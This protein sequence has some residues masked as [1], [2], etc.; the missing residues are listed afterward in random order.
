MLDMNP[1]AGD[2]SS[3]L[4]FLGNDGG[5]YL[6]PLNP[7]DIRTDATNDEDNLTVSDFD[8]HLLP[9][10]YHDDIIESFEVSAPE[11]SLPRRVA[12]DP[13]VGSQ[14]VE[15]QRQSFGENAHFCR[16]P[17]WTECDMRLCQLNLD[18]CKQLDRQ[19]H[20][21]LETTT[22]AQRGLTGTNGC[23]TF[24]DAFG[25]ALNNTEK[26]LEILQDLLGGSPPSASSSSTKSP[27]IRSEDD[28]HIPSNLVCILGLESC[29]FRIVNLF[30]LHLANMHEQSRQGSHDPD[31][32]SLPLSSPVTPSSPPVL[33]GLRLAGF[34]VRQAG[35]Q[36][37]ILYQVIQH[38][39]EMIEKFLGLPA[40]LRVSGRRDEDDDLR[41]VLCEFWV[42]TSLMKEGRAYDEQIQAIQVLRERIVDA[43]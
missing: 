23:S 42:T 11:S 6:P 15:R 35:L 12:K 19:I 14:R 7:H 2:T 29:Y 9:E 41:G 13:N 30:N 37:K 39:F 24:G 21:S 10:D 5:Q 43:R 18:L 1:T 38:Q 31:T 27:S 28:V 26:Y 33:P 25:D 40:E 17:R 20:P 36:A 16:M 8:R 32:L 34:L 22:G 4:W 3:L